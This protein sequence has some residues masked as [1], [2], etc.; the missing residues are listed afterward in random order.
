MRP[1]PPLPKL[2]KCKNF[3]LKKSFSTLILE[4]QSNQTCV[5]RRKREKKKEKEKQKE[6]GRKWE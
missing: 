4:V 3:P 6:K 2:E 1:D 5:L